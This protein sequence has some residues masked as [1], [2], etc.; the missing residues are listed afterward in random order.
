M[1]DHRHQPLPGSPPTSWT[2]WARRFALTLGV[3][4]SLVGC[5]AAQTS[6]TDSDAR[7]DVDAYSGRY[8]VTFL[9]DGTVA[10]IADLELTQGVLA[11]VITATDGAIF[12]VRGRVDA[13]GALTYEPHQ[14]SVDGSREQPR[15]QGQVTPRGVLEGSYALGD[16]DGL[17]F[18]FRYEDLD[19]PS[20]AHDGQWALDFELEGQSIGEELITV[21]KG[22]FAFDFDA[23]DVEVSGIVTEGGLIL[24]Q[25]AV[26]EL[27]S[28]VLTAANASE[29]ELDGIFYTL[30][31][32]RGAVRGSRR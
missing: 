15:G 31:G 21:D 14:S 20:S 25:S 1:N 8:N 19:R 12:E 30:S 9:R 32:Q 5:D 22:A 4:L 29:R 2:A 13:D 23:L 3:T 10:A 16:R 18:G 6:A 11:G 27:G 17:Y 24:A 26:P 28:I 7:D